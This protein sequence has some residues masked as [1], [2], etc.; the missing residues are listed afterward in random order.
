MSEIH[1]FTQYI[2]EDTGPNRRAQRLWVGIHRGFSNKSWVR[3]WTLTVGVL[4]HEQ[5]SLKSCYCQEHE[6]SEADTVSQWVIGTSDLVWF[7]SMNIEPLKKGLWVWSP[8]DNSVVILRFSSL[9][10][11]MA[12]CPLM[13]FSQ[14]NLAI[15]TSKKISAKLL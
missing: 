12:I 11:F 8:Y 3:H 4:Q 2:H 13:H 10:C 6:V 15:K 9:A 14:I 7:A 1:L 5:T